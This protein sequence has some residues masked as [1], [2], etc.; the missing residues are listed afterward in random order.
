MIET[1][2]EVAMLCQLSEKQARGIY[3]ALMAAGSFANPENGQSTAAVISQSVAAA[4]L[5]IER[6]ERP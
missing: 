2:L 1:N 5:L 6:L 3:A 4:D